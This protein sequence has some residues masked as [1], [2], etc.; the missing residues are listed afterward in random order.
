MAN[1]YPDCNFIVLDIL[2]Y[3]ASL[4]NLEKL[5]NIELVIGDIGNSELVAYILR[6]FH[7][8]TVVHFAAQSHVDNSFFNSIQ[9]TKTNV[10]GTHVL[11]ETTRIY[12]EETGKLKNL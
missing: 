5:S 12:H 2:D 4:Q 7:V 6:K 11:L 10:L 3:C 1:K 9:F 8:D